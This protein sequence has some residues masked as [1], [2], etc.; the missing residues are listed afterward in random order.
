VPRISRTAQL[1]R[2]YLRDTLR[3]AT[4]T[5]E[6]MIKKIYF[7]FALFCLISFG[8]TAADLRPETLIKLSNPSDVNDIRTLNDSVNAL[9]NRVMECVKNKAAL[10]DECYCRYPKEL[11]QLREEY[12]NI[13]KLHPSWQDRV[14]FWWRDEKQ[15]Y[16]YNLSL[17][18][19]RMQFEKNC[20]T[21]PS[22][23][24]LR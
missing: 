12:K 11:S 14:I 10:P 17:K 7:V 9:S 1:I 15:D 2:Q 23:G 5:E 3:W 8:S 19:L 4:L 18:G 16:S 22:S 6:F 20:P 21:H 24:T 13:L